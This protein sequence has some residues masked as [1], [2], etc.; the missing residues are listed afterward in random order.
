MVLVGSKSEETNNMKILIVLT[1]ACLGLNAWSQ[2]TNSF[3]NTQIVL[4]TVPFADLNGD[5]VRIVPSKWTF[6]GTLIAHVECCN[7]NNV[8][9]NRVYVP[10]TG[11]VLRQFA[12]QSATNNA[13]AMKN[14]A[15]YCAKQ[16]GLTNNPAVPD[17]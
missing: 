2:Q 12:T 11:N 8:I 7:S 4:Y 14:L 9:I 6:D 17:K 10:I 15:I 13:L 3:D 5:H 16:A 1:L